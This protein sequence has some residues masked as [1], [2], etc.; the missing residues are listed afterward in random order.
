MDV[1]ISFS[2]NLI[3]RLVLCPISE[4]IVR[5]LRLCFIE[6]LINLTILSPPR[7]FLSELTTY[8]TQR[9]NREKPI[10]EARFKTSVTLSVRGR[11]KLHLSLPSLRLQNPEQVCITVQP[12]LNIPARIRRDIQRRYLSGNLALA[13][14]ASF[15]G[16][17]TKNQVKHRT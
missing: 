13:F 9:S 14:S 10:E 5:P 1:E 17:M 16:R 8:R 2:G 4:L 11:Y 7:C 6:I 12:H 3:R 15:P